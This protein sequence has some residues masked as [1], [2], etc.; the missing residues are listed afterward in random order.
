MGKDMFTSQPAHPVP[1]FLPPSLPL[2]R[3]TLAP[4]QFGQPTNNE[5]WSWANSL[6]PMLL[7]AWAQP[8]QRRHKSAGEHPHVRTGAVG[9]MQA[10]S[11]GP[12][13]LTGLHPPSEAMSPRTLERGFPLYICT[14]QKLVGP[15]FAI[16]LTLHPFMH[17][18]KAALTKR[19]L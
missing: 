5:A 2:P 4:A 16:I 13:V 17:G 8:H 9:S 6:W 15:R 11:V 10:P 1:S 3:N 7:L 19:L 12:M 18:R 14:I